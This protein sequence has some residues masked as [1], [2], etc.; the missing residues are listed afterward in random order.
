MCHSQ[1]CK[2][3]DALV[4]A[5]LQRVYAILGTDRL[6]ASLT[7]ILRARDGI[8]T[9]TTNLRTLLVAHHCPALRSFA[10]FGYKW[11]RHRE[12]RLEMGVGGKVEFP[13]RSVRRLPTEAFGSRHR[14]ESIAENQ[15][16]RDS[17][18][19]SSAYVHTKWKE[20]KGEVLTIAAVSS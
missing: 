19:G 2:R 1:S 6:L 14:G 8:A 5:R 12:P 16:R 11:A 10:I 7:A 9:S 4:S 18:R 15:R 17:S 13:F 3:E 20:R